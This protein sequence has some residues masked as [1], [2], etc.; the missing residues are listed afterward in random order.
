MNDTVQATIQNVFGWCALG[1]ELLA[2]SVIET[3]SSW[4]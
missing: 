4:L 1:I 3:A 2:V